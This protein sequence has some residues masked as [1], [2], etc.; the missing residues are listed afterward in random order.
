MTIHGRVAERAALEGVVAAGAPGSTLALV[1]EAG[2]G[3][4]RL[5]RH[6]AEAASSTGR[7]VIE[8]HT[9]LGLTEPLGVVCDAVRAARRAGLDP[10]PARD[11]LANGFPR[12]VL[13]E[14]GGGA[15][16]AG[17][18]G[19]T[20]DAAA[21]YLR[22]LAGR[23]GL[24]LI[25]EDLHWA[26]AT[27]LS[28]VPFLT[29]ALARDP[30]AIVLTYRP[31]EESG[32]PALAT[33]R[34][35][36]SRGRL[37]EE[38][39][40]EPLEPH[41]AASMLADILAVRPA[42]DVQAE[43]L[44]LSGGNPFAL[45]ELTR[46]AVDSGWIDAA[47]GRRQG[48]GSVSL[49]WTLAESIRARSSHLPS[50]VRE[51]I[52]WAAAIGERFDL[53]LL[54]GAADVAP[55]EAVAGLSALAAAGLIVEDAG[56]PEGSVFSFRHA[57]VHEALSQEGF[58]A[59]RRSRH[60]RILAVA[61]DLAGR[62]A[63]EISAAE[64]AGH[65]VAAGDRE[66]GLA[67]SRT[68][69]AAA[70]ELGA[71]G[72]AVT[73]LERALTLWR[74]EDGD[75]ARAELLFAC[76]RLRTRLTRGDERAIDLLEQ[77][78]TAYLDLGDDTAAAWCLAVLADARFK[79][80]RRPDALRD[81]AEAMP[82]LR[83]G[84]PREAL[85][86]SLAAHARG[87]ALCADYRGA[88]AAADEGL[89]LVQAPSTM[90]EALDRVSLL[91]TKAIVA[92]WRHEMTS[93]VALVDEATRLALEHH[94]DVGAALALD[95]RSMAGYGY[96]PA[97]DAMRD[98]LRA[99]ELV[100]RH[101][102][103]SLQAFYLALAAGIAAAAG[104][105]P[106][107]SRWANEAD[108]LLPVDSDRVETA[109][110]I[111]CARA[112]VLLGLG[113]LDGALEIAGAMLASDLRID[114]PR[115]GE[116][117]ENLARMCLAAGDVPG[118]L[119]VLRPAVDALLAAIAADD[120][121]DAEI[122]PTAVAV[123]RAGGEMEE[124]GRIARWLGQIVGDHAWFR[125]CSA[126]ADP[127]PGAPAAGAVEAAATDLES[128]GWRVLGALV[129]LQAAG[130]LRDGGA[131][132]EAVSLMR[133]ALDRFRAMGSDAWCG[134]IEAMLRGMGERA[135]T[136]R[137]G[138]GPGGLTARESEVLG[139]VAEGLTNRE[140][141]E[142][143]VL[144]ENTVIRHIANIFGKLG[145]RNRAAAVATAAGR[146]PSPQSTTLDLTGP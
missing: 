85:R 62:G 140:I 36:L 110:Y 56:D 125:L 67:L 27:S 87:L 32:N 15:G 34:A 103:W 52:A 96:R 124:A 24:L 2:I 119:A 88:S 14:L 50:P 13:H 132:E 33:L 111:D 72:E 25:L 94:D 115:D 78:R 38:L 31:D 11:P 102:L 76:G 47:S 133:V 112:D 97:A 127:S 144:S 116:T 129:R 69:A 79:A 42:P 101:G 91:N 141:A 98:H 46:A 84:A 86:S 45:E 128:D 17:H 99:A 37:G 134:R 66:R 81:W 75:V 54:A 137:K 58:S 82:E 10:G 6:T 28:L 65:A 60:A 55:E 130:I 74:D 41:E 135:P 3:K 63:L 20:F 143:L 80:A 121:W 16:E 70:Q 113:D 109:R 5:A 21:R 93:G 83:R 131:P 40:I 73:H 108:D 61:E 29:R 64:L 139:L 90:Q 142:R 19:A 35:E 118:A 4:T 138:A 77:A 49:P 117:R 92:M 122:A 120:G 44:R 30:V 8:G 12:L 22:A 23:R 68:A 145:V 9:V 51:L 18:L 71:V 7:V 39:A 95:I 107:A 123:L 114:D 59:Q 104:D 136:R 100:S 53:R 126:L 105:F 106:N 89:A 43:L 26:D 1:G 57:L 146:A 48:T